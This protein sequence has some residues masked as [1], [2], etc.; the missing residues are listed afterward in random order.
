MT[1]G[2][3]NSMGS[4]MGNGSGTGKNP[5]LGLRYL[6]ISVAAAAAFRIFFLWWM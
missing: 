2:C 6:K 1:G 5:F 3:S 4:G